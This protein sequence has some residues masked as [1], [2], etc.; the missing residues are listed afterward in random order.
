VSEGTT[1]S[2]LRDLRSIVDGLVLPDW[3]KAAV[4][5]NLVQTCDILASNLLGQSDI[6]QKYLGS[7]FRREFY[8]APIDPHDIYENYHQAQQDVCSHPEMQVSD[9]SWPECTSCGRTFP[10]GLIRTTDRP[11]AAVKNTVAEGKALIRYDLIPSGPL[12]LLATLY[13]RGALKY[14]ERNWEHGFRWSTPFNAAVRHMQKHNSGE[15]MDPDTGVP[16]VIA[17]AWNML[18]IAEFI[19]THPELDDRKG[20]PYVPD[21]PTGG[22]S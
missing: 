4:L 19:T 11:T 15:T 7:Q 10:E 12:E 9:G 20:G 16:H 18:A 6:A 8:T 3:A 2:L 1:E 13:G 17:A 21:M 14:S 5:D 22:E